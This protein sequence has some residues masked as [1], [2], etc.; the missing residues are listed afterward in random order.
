MSFA[1]NIRNEI[2]DHV[3]RG[4]SYTPPT[5]LYLGLFTSSDGLDDNDSGEQDEL[6]YTGYARQAV[7]AGATNSFSAAATSSSNNTAAVVF[8]VATSDGGIPTHIAL[9]DAISGGNVIAWGA[10][11]MVGGSSPV[12]TGLGV[13]V[14]PGAIVATMT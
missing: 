11:T 2:L 6:S 14:D 10:L 7:R 1:A 12:T 3:L 9:L 4:E 13:T 5:S 8:P